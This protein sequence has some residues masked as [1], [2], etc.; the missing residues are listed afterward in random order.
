M[1][2]TITQAKIDLTRNYLFMSRLPE[3]SKDTLNAL[4][5]A[6]STSAN[7][8]QDKIQALS[9]TLLALA[10]HEV[11]Q[12]VRL[13]DRIDTAARIAVEEHIQ[14]CPLRGSPA[15]MSKFWAGV[16]PF[17]WP[18]TILLS[19]ASFAPQAPTLLKM[20]IDAFR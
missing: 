3:D 2:D 10:I 19:V 6:A 18:A 12:A 9:D 13:P 15:G 11:K 17:R 5:D 16:Y 8:V 20:A 1:L 7:G 14:T 4:L